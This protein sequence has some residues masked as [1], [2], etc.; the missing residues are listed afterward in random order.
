MIGP[1]KK[2]VLSDYAAGRRGTRATIEA[3]DLRDYGD[4]I[5]ALAGADLPFP[6]PADSPTIHAH[7]ERASALL[8]PR[9][10]AHGD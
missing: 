5:M 1:D 3:L 2:A 4:L 10:V 8:M 6:P 9:L 7:R